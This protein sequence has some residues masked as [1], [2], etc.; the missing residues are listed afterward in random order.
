MHKRN[1]FAKRYSREELNAGALLCQ[2]CH[3]GLH[4]LYSEIELASR[5]NSL[6]ALRADEAVA[7]HVAWAA[8]QK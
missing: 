2:R 3:R 1:R 4:N 6:A 8:K 7:R 5:L